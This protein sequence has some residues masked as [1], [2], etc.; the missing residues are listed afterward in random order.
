MRPGET[1]QTQVEVTKARATRSD[2]GR[3][4]VTLAFAVT[5]ESGPVLTFEATIF[6]RS[7]AGEQ[8]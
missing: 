2:P 1:L 3:G 7:R 5:T 6:V 8:A 4:V